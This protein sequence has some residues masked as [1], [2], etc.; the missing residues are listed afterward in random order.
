VLVQPYDPRW[1]ARF[2][3]LRD[4]LMTI[5]GA[6]IVRIEHVGS[7]A[8][9][10]LAAKP[11][12][13]IDVVIAAVRWHAV[14]AAFEDAGYRHV[15]DQDVP[16]R[17]V[18]KPRDPCA[19]PASW[20]KHHLYVCVDGTSELRR[21]VAFRDYLRRHPTELQRLAARKWEIARAPGMDKERYQEEKSP[22]VLEMI[23]CAL[24]EAGEPSHSEADGATGPTEANSEMPNK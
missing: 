14:R 13:D 17:E 24:T 20:P 2:E 22:L 11:T 19:A 8:V 23:E 6:H 15:G 1:P 9:P 7:T 16:G 18:F 4:R 10:G 5:A 3:S 12:I 21:H